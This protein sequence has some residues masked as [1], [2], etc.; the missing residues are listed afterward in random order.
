[1]FTRAQFDA[2]GGRCGTADGRGKGCG[3]PLVPAAPQDLRLR[4]IVMALS[5]TIG[6]VL[7]TIALRTYVFPAPLE[8]IGFSVARTYVDSSAGNIMLEIER[9]GDA[10]STVTLRAVF[11]DGSAKAGEDYVGSGSELLM[12]P[13]QPKVRLSIPLLPDRS[14]RKGERSFSVVLENVLGRPQHSVVIAPP[15]MNVGAQVQ[16]DH[17]V[18]SASRIAAD[19]AGLVVKA[20][21]MEQLLAKFRDRPVE[22]QEYRQQM[23]DT[24]E[25]LVRAREAYKQAIE[26]LRAQPP[27]QVLAAIDRLTRDLKQRNFRQQAAVLPVMGRQY[28]ELLNG[29]TPDMDRWVQE[30][31]Q[32]IP[33]V[34]SGGSP[35]ANT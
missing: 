34:P 9:S 26:G 19:I 16:L 31:G 21:T 11:I 17:T 29:E 20:E 30:L 13:G 3:L 27:Q 28:Q 7:L 25:N 24:S 33:R 18:L 10:S 2:W 1:M 22:F 5:A 23:K 35:T 14:F 8:D 4:L 12:K 32:T 15:A 6:G